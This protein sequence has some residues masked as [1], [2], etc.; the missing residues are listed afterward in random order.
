MPNELSKKRAD[1]TALKLKEVE[2]AISGRIQEAIRDYQFSDDFRNEAGKDATYCLCRFT[3]TYKE[4]N[5]AIEENYREFIQGY[6]E[7]WSAHCNLESPL[8]PEDEGEEDPFPEGDAPT[9]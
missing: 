7:E 8:T 3:R 9:S 6:D 2:E 4:A 5:P 1:D